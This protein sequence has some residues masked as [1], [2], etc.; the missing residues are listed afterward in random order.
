MRHSVLEPSCLFDF[1]VYFEYVREYGQY[2]AHTTVI[3]VWYQCV[4]LCLNLLKI[5]FEF[6]CN[7]C[8]QSAR[9]FRK[10]V[11]RKLRAHVIATYWNKCINEKSSKRPYPLRRHIDIAYNFAHILCE[12]PAIIH[13]HTQHAYLSKPKK[14][15]THTHTN[16]QRTRH[17]INV[18]AEY[19]VYWQRDE[20]KRRRRRK[21]RS[22]APEQVGY[23]IEFWDYRCP[24][25]F[26]VYGDDIAYTHTHTTPVCPVCFSALYHRYR[27]V[28]N[29]WE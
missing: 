16:I 11:I 10:F 18:K 20:R 17:G 12:L 4:Y 5:L 29:T 22:D 6:T 15:K 26:T 3:S 27:S 25:L 2:L 24:G 19:F 1:M 9:K 8:Y 28:V 14:K 13:N 7:C 23:E 21:K